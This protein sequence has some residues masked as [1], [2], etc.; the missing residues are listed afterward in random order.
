MIGSL[1]ALPERVVDEKS[2]VRGASQE[3]RVRLRHA[4]LDDAKL[5]CES[6][7]ADT[8]KLRSNNTSV[9]VKT[10]RIC[11]Q[12]MQS[13]TADGEVCENIPTSSFW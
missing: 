1:G 7:K 5:Q 6:A 12:R 9:I 3:P 10:A 8:S 11:T 4:A 13:E 2:S